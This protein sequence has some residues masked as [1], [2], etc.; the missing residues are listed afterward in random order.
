MFERAARTEG[1]APELSELITNAPDHTTT[2][3]I[4]TAL[5]VVC[6]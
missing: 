1:Y 6:L 5:T 3:T 2:N 4:V